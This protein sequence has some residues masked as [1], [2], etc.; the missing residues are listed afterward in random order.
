MQKGLFNIKKSEAPKFDSRQVAALVTKRQQQGTLAEGEL[1]N[2][3]IFFRPN[4]TEFSLDLYEK[5]FTKVVRL[6]STYG[7]AIITVEGHS[8][9]LGYLKRKKARETSVVLRQI[10]QSAKNLSVSRAAAV[11]DAV[12]QSAKLQG[13]GLDPSQ[14]AV[15]GHG[16]GSPR[17]GMC[18]SDPCPPKT[19]QQWLSNMR[20]VFRIVQV[21]AEADVFKPL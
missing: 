12:I 14:F 7:G 11:R 5:E 1:F 4:Q 21:E 15:T 17:T 6:A 2:F 18:G 20:V 10:K 9:P 19:E 8:D 3:E 16:F 13:I